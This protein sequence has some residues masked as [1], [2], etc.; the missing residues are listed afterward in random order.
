VADKDDEAPE[1][2]DEDLEDDED[3][4]ERVRDEDADEDDADEDDA[5]EDDADEDDAD[6]DDADEDDADEDD[7]D[8]DDADEDD[9]DADDDEDDADADDA[10]DADDEDDADE[11]ADEAP[12][13][14][15]RRRTRDADERA[16]EVAKALGVAGEDEE[17]AAEGEAEERPLNRAERRRQRALQRRRREGAAATEDEAGADRNRRRRE[18][19]LERRRRAAEAKEEP[20]VTQLTATEMMDDA[21]A[22]GTA[23]GVAWIKRNWKVIQWVLVAGVV[24]GIGFA[25]WTYQ[26]TEKL[27][28]ASTLLGDALAAEAGVVI[29]PE[30]DKRT[31][32]EKKRYL[33]AVFPNEEARREAALAAYGAVEEGFSGTGPAILAQLGRAGLRLDRRDWDGALAGYQA[34]IDSE[35]AAADPDVRA[36]ALEGKAFALENKGDLDGA[37]AAFVA[38]GD[39]GGKVYAATSKYHQARIHRAKKD[40]EKA[41]ALLIEL[42]AE[43]EKA[44]L[45]TLGADLG[46]LSPVHPFRWL[47][48]AATDLLKA[49]DPNAIPPAQGAS[50]PP[51]KL[52]ELLEQQGIQPEL[53]TP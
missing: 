47:E 14:A 23:A 51:D 39:V 48:A 28:E 29:P 19:L 10:E 15:R 50:I 41:K 20:A 22:R 7:A 13:P 5:D 26:T 4:D 45:E 9:A 33:V 37:L 46:G 43:I 49:I 38:V 34:V 11:D 32:E 36:R 53:P 1:E 31:D 35:L 30:E 3:L 16:A 6:E 2:R 25:V 24:G 12:R 8:E 44:K 18:R 52:R 17:E 40:D 21:L 42:R 27:T